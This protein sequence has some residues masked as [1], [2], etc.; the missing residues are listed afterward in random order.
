MTE[1]ADISKIAIVGSGYMGG[2]M[3]QVFA[4]SGYPCA[5]ADATVDIA[6]TARAR[7]VDEAYAFELQGIV[8]KGSAE[9]I[10]QNLSFAESIEEAAA[11]ADYIAEAV[12]ERR[13]TKGEVLERISA[14][15]R[16]D[17]ILATNTSAIPIRELARFVQ[18]PE[19][20]LGVHWMNPAPFVPG[21]ELVPWSGTEEAVVI[22]AKCLMGDLGKAA[23]RVSDTPGFVANRLQF[24]LFREACL[25]LEEGLATPDQI[26]E[27]VSNSFGFRLAF[28]GPFT[29]ADMAG[30]DVYA[31]AYE[32]LAAAYGD[33]F[34]VPR[35]LSE[36]VANGDLGVKTGAGYTPYDMGKKES[37]VTLRNAIYAALTQL[38]TSFVATD[39]DRSNSK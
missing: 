14:A 3:A 12:S 26:D 24:A 17:C 7:L 33:R 18:N 27:V 39:I 31:G 2:G 34:T 13:E 37:L 23:T 29:I 11:G 6:R 20:F 4:R 5:L 32:T 1:K 15:C 28:F 35:S 19:R 30:L 21:V 8:D 22:R 16:P 9:L 38:K 36:K 25:M 10:S